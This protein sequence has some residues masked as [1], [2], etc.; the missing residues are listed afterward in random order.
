M[1]KREKK[2]MVNLGNF[3]AVISFNLAVYY[4]GQELTKAS[5]QLYDLRILLYKISFMVNFKLSIN[6]LYVFHV[7]N[8]PFPTPPQVSA[9]HEA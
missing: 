6:G 1:H 9:L 2:F 5:T 8:F 3:W 4:T 7:G